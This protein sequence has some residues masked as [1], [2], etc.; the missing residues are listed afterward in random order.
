[1]MNF[2]LAIIAFNLFL[3][4]K[5]VTFGLVV[6]DWSHYQNIKNG[7]FKK[8]GP[9]WVHISR[10]LYGGGTFGLDVA[11]DHLVTL[12]LHIV[13]CLMIFGAFGSNAVSFMAALLYA[14]H[15]ANHQTAVWLNGRRY[16]INVFLVL[17]ML[18]I[19]PAGLILWPLTGIL[20]ESAILAPIIFGPWGCLLIPCACFVLRK[21]MRQKYLDRLEKIL[22]PDVRNWSVK[23]LIVVVKCYGFYVRRMLFPGRTLFV[24]PQLNSWGNTIEG[25][26]DAYAF[27]FDFWQGVAFLGGSV[28]GI[29][30][31]GEYRWMALFAML[32]TLQWCAFFPGVQTLADRYIALPNVFVMFFVA[33]LPA[34]IA[35][36]LLGYYVANLTVTL[37]MYRDLDALWDYHTY[38]YPE[39]VVLRHGQALQLFQRGD[40]LGAWEATRKGL[41]KNPND[42]RM[43]YNA[44]LCCHMMGDNN[45]AKS[46]IDRASEN[47]YIGQEKD[48]MQAI[49]NFREKTAPPK[50]KPSNGRRPFYM[51][52]KR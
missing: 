22:S 4:R 13:N 20:Q 8:D 17:A 7:L 19:G 2:V 3:Y 31:A 45:M 16:A 43:L 42:F 46:Y 47:L 6:D 49:E 23:R 37:R 10:R 27:N 35:L 36:A 5:A 11:R 26:K 38:F 24:Y 25:N 1:M 44:A 28:I 51:G 9:W 29:A 34:P 21:H 32:G 52:V 33:H 30:F 12:I 41:E 39:N 15:P 14:A 50:K 18:L 48:L 40:V